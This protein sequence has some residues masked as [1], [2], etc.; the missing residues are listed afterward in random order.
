MYGCSVLCSC[1][2]IVVSNGCQLCDMHVNDEAHLLLLLPSL[3]TPLPQAG[4][5][6]GAAG[7]GAAGPAL[8]ESAKPLGP[9]LP[10]GQL[11]MASLI[12][13]LMNWTTQV[14]GGLTQCGVGGKCTMSGCW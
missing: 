1:K 9:P 4:M 8:P 13:G 14:R 2:H 3:L 11:H 6:G 7:A 5:D 10:E 12:E